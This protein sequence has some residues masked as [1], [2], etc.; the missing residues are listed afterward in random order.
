VAVRDPYIGAGA[1]HAGGVA[2]VCAVV[3]GSRGGGRLARALASVAWAGERVVLD[4]ANRL[5]AE[6]V[7]AGVRRERGPRPADV[8][9]APW[10]LLLDEDETV[11]PALAAAVAEAIRAEASCPAYRIAQ[12]VHALGA[13]LRPRRDSVRL[14]R[15]DGARLAL[16]RGLAPALSASGTPGQLTGALEKEGAASLGEAVDDLDA[17]AGMLA[18]LLDD[19]GARP[20]IRTSVMAFLA[21]S[22]RVLWAR[23]TAPRCWSR[24]S[25][26][27]LAGYRA[28]VAYAKLWELRWTSGV[29]AP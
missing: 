28:M 20:G 1:L 23:G 4:P 19:A 6:E 26:A 21:A 17:Y 10:L 3:L 18:A 11:P 16:G 9:R 5:A 7:P 29:A 24:W 15:R 14:A 22:G 13:R 25:L 8:T 2:E 12:E 27:L